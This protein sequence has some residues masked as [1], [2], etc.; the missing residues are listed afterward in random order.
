MIW[1]KFS[2]GIIWLVLG[3]VMIIGLGA[4]IWVY[5]SSPHLAYYD[6]VN[7]DEV[8][9]DEINFDGVNFDGVN[10]E[11][12]AEET[13][14]ETA[15]ET[16]EDAAEFY[17][18]GDLAIK[19]VQFMSEN[20]YGRKPFSYREREAAY[21]LVGELLYLGLPAESIYLQEFPLIGNFRWWALNNEARWASE[22]K[23]R[24]TQVS[25]NIIVTI[26]GQSERKIIVGAHYDSHPTP[27]ASD[28]A[29]GTSLL[30][31]SAWRMLQMDN[32]YTIVYV[33]FGGHEAGGFL[34]ADFFAR[35]LTYEQLDNI[36]FMINA[37]N[38][39][40]G[41]YIFY[42]AAYSYNHG[43]G[44]NELTLEIDAIANEL[45]LGLIKHPPVAFMGSDHQAFL[46]RGHTVVHFTGLNRMEL[47]GY[48]GFFNMDGGEFT[49]GV[50][51]TQ[52]D[53]FHIIET[54]WPDMIKTNMQ[55]FAVFLEELLMMR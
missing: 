20:L 32:Y 37:D 22:F 49:R 29:S 10:A 26:P 55:A 50:S 36:V 24:Q 48:K 21:W 16:L 33:F 38:L 11:E 45:D 2:R 27:G 51:H 25:Q 5:S 6:E 40:D 43:P 46:N 42:G 8:N 39:L 47:P 3:A 15:E 23:M 54:K 13:I 1:P 9:F 53:D 35:S 52:N 31:E 34:A 30:L 7:F 18:H 4:L 19:Y 44:A 14:E 17:A 28:N 12:S 41:P